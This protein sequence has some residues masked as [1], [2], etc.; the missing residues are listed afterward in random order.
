MPEADLA[1]SH[2]HSEHGNPQGGYVVAY[3]LAR[4]C[5]PVTIRA[6]RRVDARCALTGT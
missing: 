6:D 4:A 5:F 1:G 2:I 3:R